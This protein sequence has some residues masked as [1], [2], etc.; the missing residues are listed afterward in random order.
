MAETKLLSKVLSDKG[1]YCIVGLRKD[2]LPK[3]VFVET[4]E[5]AEKEI[6]HLVENQYDAYFAC[7][8]YEKKGSRT[9]DNAKYFKAFWLDIDCGEGKHY[10]TREE[11]LEALEEFCEE[12]GLPTP[13]TVNSGRGVHA[14]WI[15]ETEIDRDQWKPV[16]ETLKALCHKHA[17]VAD[18]A[19]TAD[20]ARILRVPGTFNHKSTP[21]TP[22]E[23]LHEAEPVNYF[24]FTSKLGPIK[25]LGPGPD[26]KAPLNELT[27]A[28]M[29][30]QEH[31]FRT[32]MLKTMNDVG[33][34]Q[35]KHI[36]ENQTEV[37]EPLW[38]AGLSIAAFCADKAK[39]IHRM[40][41]HHP[42]YN[43]AVTEQKANEIRGPYTC[44]KFNGLN[45]GVCDGCHNRGKVKSPIVL[46]REFLMA[47]EED[48]VV[49]IK[50]APEEEPVVYQIPPYPN[51]YLRGKN[52][53]VYL[54]ND[55]DDPELVYEH[56]L[57]VL[58]RMKDPNRGAVVL[59]RLHLPRDG[60]KEFAVPNTDVLA[61][62]KCKEILAF[63]GVIGHKKQMEKIANYIITFIKELTY[64]TEIEIMR[65]QFGWADNDKKFIVGDREIST[66]GVRYSPPSH[67]T[68]A[69]SAFMEPV[70]SLETW[71][72]VI[73]NYNRPGYEPHAFG[74]FTAFGS[75]LIKH[76]NLNGALINL[77]NNQSG[78][79]KTTV[80]K[81]MHSVWGHPEEI[82]LMYKDTMNVMMHRFGVLGNL[83]AG[84]DE[85]TNM[86]AEAVSDLAYMSSQ[87]RGKNRMRS[88]T[89]EERVNMARWA[90]IA[91]CSS[92]ASLTDKL[93]SLKATPDGELM[94]LIEYQLPVVGDISKV[95]ADEIFPKLYDNYGH[96]GAIY[97]KWLVGNLEEAI[98]IVRKVQ[99]TIDTQV[100]MT[101][102]ERFWSAVAAC[103]I[104]G[105]YIAGKLGLHDIDIGRILRWTIEM[106]KNM[107]MEIKPPSTNK[108][109]A[110]GEYINENI[111]S[112]AIVN[113]ELD[114]RTNVEALPILEPKN[115]KLNIR[116]EPDT[117][118]LFIA[119]KQFR[120]YCS[121][122]QITLKDLLNSLMDEGIYVGTV[123]KRMA[124]G[125]KIPSPAVDAYV[126]D[127]SVPDFIDPAEY[128]EAL[129][130]GQDEG[131]RD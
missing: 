64:K 4:L 81:A 14:Y 115:G 44:E 74:F 23:V 108:T 50:A 26:D 67:M 77:I 79:G 25:S 12:T 57:Y 52:G 5:E 3:Q 94:R 87:G 66:D 17:L 103:N 18:P 73:N 129:K 93:R 6:D 28:L 70:G 42:D 56:D 68:S 85:V 106:L 41:E 114:K 24:D 122:N 95:E 71:K 8:K 48:N 127:C 36:V 13:T 75:P 21:P 86:A 53:G 109:S 47:D 65:T 33:C 128:V 72:E 112:F 54:V 119:V 101:S 82:M 38:R 11:G 92:N 37:E 29:G 10:E 34:P 43:P 89:N 46:G 99:V 124:K 100:K 116:M 20:E 96:A 97:A 9:K 104:G 30:N 118:K 83:P 35:L 88:Q 40:S 63:H 130:Q 90:L 1:W 107:R 111:N 31:R 27:L 102:R 69:I 84:I 126:F 78:T 120:A 123:K 51:P 22:V 7:A 131:P 32:I 113:G 45:P 15:L 98:D 58:K 61:L 49:E 105:A 2:H 19:V 110:I 55:G 80:I 91:L 60:V 39:A 59:I 76:L 16:A 125:T 117:K 62:E 121:E